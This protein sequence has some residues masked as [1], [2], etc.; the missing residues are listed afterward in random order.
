[1]KQKSKKKNRVVAYLDGEGALPATEQEMKK[2]IRKY[3]PA[4][5]ESQKKK[6]VS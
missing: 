4:E 2:W 6:K 5:D 3:L 1:M